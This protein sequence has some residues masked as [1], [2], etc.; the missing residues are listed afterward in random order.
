MD[1]TEVRRAVQAGAE[2]QVMRAEPQLPD[3]AIMEELQAVICLG[4]AAAERA[5]QE[6]QT[7]V[8]HRVGLGVL[9]FSPA[10]RGLQYITAVVAA[11]QQVVL[12]ATAVV[13]MEALTAETA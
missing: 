10:S 2:H 6:A 1:S 11:A 12:G 3:K 5:L 13:A 8:I 9:A 4:R 7:S